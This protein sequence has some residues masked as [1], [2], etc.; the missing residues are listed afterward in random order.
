MDI[1]R[2]R[3]EFPDE[4]ACRAF[5]ERIIWRDGRFCPHCG[6]MKSWTINGKSTRAGLYEC[7]ECGQQFTVT[8]KTPSHATKLPL[9]TWLQALY[10][11]LNSSKGV[12]SVFLAK[13]IGVSQKTAWKMGHAIREMM[14]IREFAPAL[15][16]VVELDEKYLGGKPR[17]KRDKDGNAVK[18]KRGHGTDK[19]PIFV[20]VERHGQVRAVTFDSDTVP[21]IKGL[22]ERFVRP[23]AHLM[24][25]QHSAYQIVGKGFAAHSYVNHGSKEYV[26]A[27]VHNNTAE[28]FN[29]QL[30][31][32]KQGVFHWLSK[33]H[34]QRY[35]NE[36]VFRW[37][38]RRAVEKVTK[39]GERK[40]VM[41]T[42]PIIEQMGALLSTA[43]G[44]QVR[45]T[46]DG[47]IRQVVAM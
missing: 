27:G 42:L 23:D 39:A 4:T 10:F 2:L 43:F 22:T 45:R 26:R 46:S 5:F 16:G 44:R 14:E 20:A 41:E 15:A 13:W 38:Q 34:V 47:G 24:T 17:F 8:T 32:A 37:N 40:V 30:E 31:R 12:S 6:G 35:I 7:G 19:Q 3:K 18:H 9:W 21:T 33:D 28:S 36:V 25:D 1:D 29:S 11:I